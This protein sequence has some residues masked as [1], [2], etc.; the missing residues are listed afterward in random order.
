MQVLN[1]LTIGYVGLPPRNILYMMC[2]HQANFEPV[3]FQDLKHRNPVN[4]RGL[5]RHRSNAT[6]LKPI[7]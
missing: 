7:G 6:A 1:P 5:H 2:I 3:R 4:A